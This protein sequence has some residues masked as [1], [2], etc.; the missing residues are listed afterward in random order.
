MIPQAG[1]TVRGTYV[2]GLTD[3]DIRELDDFEGKEY[4]RR[5]VNIKLGVTEEGEEEEVKAET[6][7]FIAGEKK[8]ERKEWDFK[9]FRESKMH[10]WLPAELGG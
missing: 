2:T 6:Y 9:D 8:L 4:D 7:I 10:M 1:H 3:A 5:S